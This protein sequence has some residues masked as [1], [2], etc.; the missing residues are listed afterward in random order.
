MNNQRVVLDGAWDFQLSSYVSDIPP[1]DEWRGAV[2]PMPWQAQFEDL[3]HASGVGWYRRQ[4]KLEA[5]DLQAEQSAILH[6]GA[7]DYYTAVWLNGTPVG[8]HEGGYLPFEFDV[9]QALQP[10][11]NELL[12]RVIDATDDRQIYPEF[13]FSE[14]PHGK[15]SWYGPIGGIWQSVWLEFRPKAHI[16]ELTLHPSPKEALIHVQVTLNTPPKGTYQIACL[17]M[18]PDDRVVGSTVFTETLTGVV[19]LDEA[20][21]LWS[22]ETPHLYT[23]TATL[24]AAGEVMY[25]IQ[26]QCGFRTVEARNGRIYL[27]DKPIYLR[28]MLDQAY[29]PETIYTPNS[30]ELLEEQA[31]H[32]KSLGFNCLRTHIK[33]EDPRYYDVA[34]RL[35]L[36]IWTE[37]PN[38]ALL[39]EAA[40]HRAKKT[41]REMVRR[42]GHHPSIIAWTLVNENWGTDLTR[43]PD[44]RYWLADFYEKAKA[45]DPSRLIVDNSACCDNGHVA[46]DLEDFHHYRAIPDH[47]QEWDE[48]LADFAQRSSWAWY[49]DF[50]DN[51]RS[52]LPLLVSEFGNWGL[53]DPADIQEKGKEPWWFETGMAWGEGIVYP[54]GVS[55]RFAACGLDKLFDSYADFAR[56]S[57]EHMVRSLHYEITSMRLHDS[58]AG[59]VITEFTDV[60][61]ECNGLL[62]MQRQPKHMLDPLL[63]NLNQDNVVL[64][65]PVQ[66]NGRPGQTVQIQIQTASIVAP[67]AAGTIQWQA[68][69]ASGQLAAPGDSISLILEAPGVI[70]LSADWLAEDGSKLATN[71]VDLVCVASPP[72]PTPLHI[73]GNPELAKTLQALGYETEETLLSVEV[74]PDALVVATRYTQE[75]ARFI[76]QGGK[77]ILLADPTAAG[78]LPTFPLPAGHI[79]PREGTAWQGDWANSFSWV[80]KQGPLAHLPGTPFLEMEWTAVMPD[81]V[82]EGLPQWVQQDHSWAGL[83]VGWIHKAVSLLAVLPYGKGQL[84][85]TTFKLNAQTLAH[86]AIAQALFAGMVTML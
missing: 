42:D 15:Q 35:G 33:I 81:A 25:T 38:W 27:N 82:V 21:Q 41:F 83:A 50:Q 16:S 61:W 3:R 49:D 46:G 45:I 37:I 52:D 76:Q 62:T 72:S 48:W 58:I 85:I 31:R 40:S 67:E 34:D 77:V 18:G 51:R 68:G 75:V 47:A 29:Y 6:F 63:K 53:P 60:H 20:P 54:H 71:Q 12:V 10:G 66:W 4:I 65:R 59:Y 13:P 44:H 2:V 73:V 24:Q 69:S 23:A 39:T 78:G 56:Q 5:N 64:L 32:A 14:V 55:D 80:K 1:S 57:Q 79:V 11:N 84:L 9:F 30:L 86:D 36:L 17:I 19:H 22:P 70:T 26:K 8:E 28:G 7:V 43:N 74:N